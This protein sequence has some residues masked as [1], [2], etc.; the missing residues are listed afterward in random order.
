[1][2]NSELV[3]V[4][5]SSIAD[6]VGMGIDASASWYGV[7][8]ANIISRTG[9]D[10][11]SSVDNTGVV[12][13]GMRITNNRITGSGVLMNGDAVLSLPRRS[14]AAIR[15]GQQSTVSGN[16]ILDAGNIGIKPMSGSLISGNF[17]RGACS[18]LDDCAGIYTSGK[19]NNST[20]SDNIVEHSRGALAGKP[21]TQFYTQAQ[22][23]Y[24]D[25][26]ASGV[27]VKNNTVVVVDNGI[28]LHV[29][30][31]N[32]LMHNKL[33]GNRNN[34]IWLQETNNRNRAAG[35]VYGNTVLGN[36]MVATDAQALG[37]LQTTTLY[38]TYAFAKYDKNR[39]FDKVFPT[40]GHERT[41]VGAS[42]YDLPA[43]Q[44]ATDNNGKTRELDRNG[45]GTSQLKYS[46]YRSTG[47]TVI[48]NG[49]LSASATGWT[50]W[51]QSA[52]YGTLSREACTPGYCA[53]Y[54]AG[55]SPGILS[56]PF[57]S[58][59]AGQW[60][61]I[62]LDARSSGDN[63]YQPVIVRN[64]G[65]GTAGYE[66]VSNVAMSLNASRTWKRYSF[67]FQA[68]KSVNVA[69]PATGGK[70]A[71]LDFE[72]VMPGTA[73]SI[74]NV[75]M[76]PISSVSSTTRTDIVLNPSSTPVQVGC[77]A[78]AVSA[79]LCAKYAKFSDDAAVAWPMYLPAMS[80]EIVYTVEPSLLDSDGDGVPDFQDQCP[81]SAPGSGVNAAGCG[82]GQ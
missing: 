75:E 47:G 31:N 53:T 57:F 18:V 63:Q 42:V 55:G 13:V 20:I 66:S 70:G 68:T 19:V 82:L 36:Q 71:R 61:R 67:V 50:T 11:V 58:I 39:Y 16:Y 38:N 49:K 3:N 54:V 59:V 74:S 15:S 46:T 41:P 40:I 64:G 17:V 73:I 6:T 21:A 60:Y 33:Y 79:G 52:P 26:S 22:G 62:S 69:D 23:I 30:S 10:A 77:P 76:V 44:A 24:L 37:V 78:A 28:L 51:N 65:G 43:W 56:T 7:V 32:L 14:F 25:E 45:S 9:S 27:T 1:M 29:A 81:N 4:R 72:R 34:Q 12:S 2:R 35:D 5:R 48:P 8:D 80:S